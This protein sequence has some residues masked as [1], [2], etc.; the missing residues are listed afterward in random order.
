MTTD[1]G[2]NWVAVWQSDDS[3][4]GTIGIDDC[5]AGSDAAID[6][7][8]FDDLTGPGPHVI[9]AARDFI[10]NKT[11]KIDASGLGAEYGSTGIRPPAPTTTMGSSRGRTTS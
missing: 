1:S 8:T 4:G 3:L 2:G 9:D 6:T 11:M 7:I 5:E 10:L